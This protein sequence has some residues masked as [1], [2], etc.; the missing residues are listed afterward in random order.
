MGSD[1]GNYGFTTP[2]ATLHKFNGWADLFLTTPDVGLDDIALGINGALA[3]GKWVITYHD[4]SSDE[5]N[6]DLGQELNAQY[7]RAF[8]PN[9]A[10][11]LKYANYRA[12]DVNVDTQRAWLWFSA[13]F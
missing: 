1:D 8:A 11:G 7:V 2:P 12:A 3:G 6:T 10:I 9:Y 4:F 5:G 13:K